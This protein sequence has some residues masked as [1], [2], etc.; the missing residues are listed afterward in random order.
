MCVFITMQNKLQPFIINPLTLIHFL[1]NIKNTRFELV[2]SFTIDISN[3]KDGVFRF[4]R[5]YPTLLKH[6]TCFYQKYDH[7]IFQ[8]FPSLNNTIIFVSACCIRLYLI[9]YRFLYYHTDRLFVS[10]RYWATLC[11]EKNYWY[12]CIFELFS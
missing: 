10:L 9:W 11:D 1:F 5:F 12:H 6:W 7:S 8:Y 4:I 2:F 3:L